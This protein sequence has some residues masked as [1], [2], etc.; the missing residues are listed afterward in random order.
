[1]SSVWTFLT[2]TQGRG[3]LTLT[4]WVSYAYLLLGFLIILVPV[5][6]LGLNSVKTAFQIEKQDLALLPGDFDR[7][8]R[9]TVNGPEGREI[10]VIGDAPDWVLNWKDLNAEQKAAQDVA[11]YL[12]G[13]EGRELFALRTHLDQVTTLARAEITALGLPDWLTRYSALTPQ[14]RTAFDLDVALAGLSADQERLIKEYLGV[15]PYK[16]NRIVT[17]VLV[18]APDPESGRVM[19]W[20]VPNLNPQSAFLPG[21]AVDGSIDGVVRL[22][23]DT[24]TASRNIKPAWGNFLDPLTGQAYGINVDFATCITNSVLVTIIA[25]VITLLI[26]SMA[27][28]ALSKYQFRGQVFFLAIIL[29]T[30]MVPATITLVGVFKAINA[31]GL[32]GSIW[33]VI[34]PG[35]ATPAGVFLLRQY[36]LTIPDELIEAARMDSATEW[37]V[38]WRIVLPLALPALAALGILSIIWRWNDL[39]IPMVAIATT[40]EA[41]TIQLCLLEFRG[42]HISQ[43]HYRLAMTVVS[44]IPTTLVFVFLQKYITT[45]IANT[46][47]K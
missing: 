1:M 5:A 13:K 15:D 11:G 19:Q 46:G 8:A 35:A 22:P 28:F 9:A 27:G 31:T 14:A 23:R 45:G 6:W 41:Y 18:T 29:T 47:M 26:N 44:L 37:S 12:A 7:V 33:G 42:E 36:M 2:R 24:V 38:Y 10:F 3:R 40:K 20:A 39:I 34:I 25:T 32:S 21:R 43:E 30:L 17:Q 16:P 4:D